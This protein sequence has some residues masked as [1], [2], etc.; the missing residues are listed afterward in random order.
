[1][2]RDPYYC[3][4]VTY[5]GERILGRHEALISHELFDEVQKVLDAR[6]GRGE[7]QRRHFHYLKGQLWCGICY[8][9]GTESRMIYTRV[10]GH[11][12]EYV[13]YFCRRRQEHTCR[14]KYVDEDSIE[15][16]MFDLYGRLHFP[17]DLA[18]RVRADV[19]KVIADEEDSVQL[20]RKQL[21]S[22]LQRLDTQ[23][24]NLLDM[25]A[26]GESARDKI[27]SR[28]AKI[29][30]K[31][32]LLAERLENT[33]ARL[34]IGY[35]LIDLAL[36]LLDSPLDLYRRMDGDQRRLMNQAFFERLYV[37]DGRVV[38]LVFNAPFDDLDEAK[39]VMQWTYTRRKVAFED[40]VQYDP[41]KAG[42]AWTLSDALLVQGSNKRVMVRSSLK[43]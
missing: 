22:E 41:D 7:R 31:R 20:L 36:T 9:A 38:D 23:E 40:L 2:L 5:K 32:G 43:S 17:S 13:Y 30:Q 25:A 21:Q 28:L 8:Q 37:V 1:M 24:E 35:D 39:T 4:Y 12:G 33:H 42:Q 14:A 6:S 29:Q 16:A 10:K 26:A 19:R 11:G 27:K 34:Q 18:E 3:G 15:T